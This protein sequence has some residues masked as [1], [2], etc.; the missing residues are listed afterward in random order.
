MVT[1]ASLAASLGDYAKQ[2]DIKD[3]SNKVEQ[4]TALTKIMTKLIEN[5]SNKPVVEGW[6][7]KE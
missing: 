7:E 1:A 2:R 6:F 3:V 4:L 5:T